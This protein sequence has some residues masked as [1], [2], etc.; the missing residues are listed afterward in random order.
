RGRCGEVLRVG[1]RLSLEPVVGTVALPVLTAFVASLGATQLAAF[2]VAARLEYVLY[3]L[4]FGLGAGVLALVG[5]NLG[6]GNVSRAAR[7][8]WTAAAIAALVTGCIGLFG[9]LAP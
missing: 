8:A 9:V 4:A 1:A 3:P 6:A 5:T 2:G 7:A